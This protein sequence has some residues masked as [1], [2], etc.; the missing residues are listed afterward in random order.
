LASEN[1]PSGPRFLTASEAAEQLRVSKMTI[2]RLIRAGK[3]PA[4]QV[5]KS[6]RVRV[7]DLEGYLNSSYVNNSGS[8]T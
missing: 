3:I 2:Y 4:V 6:Y 5:G 8:H 7:D 1:S